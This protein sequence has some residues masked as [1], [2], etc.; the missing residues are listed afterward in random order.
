M[1]D[2]AVQPSILVQA[3]LDRLRVELDEVESRLEGVV[4]ASDTPSTTS[5]EGRSRDKEAYV[6]SIILA[7][8]GMAKYLVEAGVL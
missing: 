3:A 1:D 8:I 2:T 7:I 6:T 5:P 4:G